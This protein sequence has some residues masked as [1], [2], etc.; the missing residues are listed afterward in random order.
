MRNYPCWVSTAI[1][2]ALLGMDAGQPASFE[3]PKGKTSM[4]V[5]PANA[6]LGKASPHCRLH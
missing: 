2:A 3:S 4:P 6:Q 1:T 5:G